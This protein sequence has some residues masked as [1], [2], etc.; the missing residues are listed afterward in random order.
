M[1]FEITCG[2]CGGELSVETAGVIVECPLCGA[3]LSIPESEF[4]G[5]ASSSEQHPVAETTSAEAEETA[6]AV[7]AADEVPTISMTSVP[8]PVESP[9]AAPEAAPSFSFERP[10]PMGQLSGEIPTSAEEERLSEEPTQVLNKQ[11]VEAAQQAVTTAPVEAV[12]ATSPAPAAPATATKP[13]AK[14]TPASGPTAAADEVVPRK[15]F[16]IV[17]SYASAA[18]LILLYFIYSSFSA[19]PHFLESLPDLVP[20][21]RKD[22]TIGMKRVLP[23]HQVA[24][25]HVLKLGESQRFGSLLV[26]PV[27]VTRGPLEFVHTY[28]NAK[29]TQPPT[30]P[31]LKLWLKF[32][33][34]SKDQAF[35]ALDRTLV[36]RRIFDP[37]MDRLFA[38][39]FLCPANGQTEDSGEIH[40]NYDMPEFSEFDLKGQALDQVI[41][42][43]ETWV[44]YIPSEEGLS[45][46]DGEWVWRVNFRKGYNRRSGRGVT[47]LIDV[48]FTGDEITAD[49]AA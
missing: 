46:V 25:G 19:K 45:K 28:G 40:L 44:S 7:H 8:E 39:N 31:V 38:L 33:N 16:I 5:E 11:A 1:A 36:F 24:P 21:I 26:T 2:A 6:V 4:A 49:S 37:Q 15:L 30:Q 22:G 10:N 27:K 32:E 43:G 18:T 13:A 14:A 17:A 3:H 42:P 41:Q 12:A 34:V 35:P 29:A 47:T 9:V 23:E 48:H 20:D